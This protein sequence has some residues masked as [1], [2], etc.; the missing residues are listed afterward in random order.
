[1][2]TRKPRSWKAIAAWGA[3]IVAVSTVANNSSSTFSTL[4][5]LF[6]KPAAVASASA[7]N[8]PLQP[9]LPVSQGQKADSTKPTSATFQASTGEQSPN[10]RNVKKG[11]R[12]QYSAPQQHGSGQTETD[13]R[14]NAVLPVTI[15]KASAVQISTGSQS[16]NISGVGGD[17]DLNFVNAS[18]EGRSEQAHDAKN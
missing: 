12:L 18:S 14:N 17:V 13:G 11:V 8:A 1:M 16:P 9:S 4:Y 5:N 3:V 7:V 10:L 15:P 2:K 6:K